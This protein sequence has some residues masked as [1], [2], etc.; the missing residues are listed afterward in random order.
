MIRR[1][2]I[3]AGL[4]LAAAGSVSAAPV[5]RVPLTSVLADLGKVHGIDAVAIS[6]D[7]RSQSARELRSG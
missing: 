4:V 6:P 7:A 3:V 1:W 5:P 2:S